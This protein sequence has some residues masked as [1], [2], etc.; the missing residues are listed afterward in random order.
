M[1]GRI[2]AVARYARIHDKAIHCAPRDNPRKTRFMGASRNAFSSFERCTSRTRLQAPWADEPSAIQASISAR[3]KSSSTAIRTS[4]HP[5]PIRR[6]RPTKIRSRG[7]SRRSGNRSR[8]A[9][10]IRRLMRFL[11]TA[12]PCFLLT[13]KP[14]RRIG[15][16]SALS[17]TRCN[18]YITARP[19]TCDL[20]LA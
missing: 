8:T 1:R 15:I 7:P 16:T 5:A 3:R 17:P 9:S 4:D 13:T 6:R 18:E 20:P 10:R 14:I 12:L 19:W 11:A 2:G